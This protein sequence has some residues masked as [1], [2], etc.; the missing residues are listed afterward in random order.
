MATCTTD[1]YILNEQLEQAM[2]LM[3]DSAIKPAT[4]FVDLGYRGVDADNPDVYFV[5]RGKSKRISAPERLQ[6]RR[7]QAIQPI[8]GHLNADQRMD[9]CHLKGELGDRLHAVLCAAGYNI[10]RHAAHAC[11][12][13]HHLLGATLFAP[14]HGGGRVAELGAGAALVADV[15][16]THSVNSR[17]HLK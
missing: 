15:G 10:R 2:I 3:Q 7:R 13:G 4:V 12:Q 17:F 9:R 11:P 5:Y 14:V 6:L 8:I 16:I 1:G